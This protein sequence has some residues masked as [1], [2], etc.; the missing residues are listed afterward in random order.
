MA[1]HYDYISRQEVHR[2]SGLCNTKIRHPYSKDALSQTDYLAAASIM[3]EKSA[4]FSDAPPI[5][6]PS[7][8]V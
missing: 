8:S 4:T 6:P 7:M 3:A 5:R 2:I 1:C